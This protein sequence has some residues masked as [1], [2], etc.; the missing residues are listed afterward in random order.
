MNE[1]DGR[2][3]ALIQMEDYCEARKRS[4]ILGKVKGIKN[5]SSIK[6]AK[7]R[8]LIP[9]VRNKDGEAEKTRQ[10]IENVFAIFYEDLYQGED[11]HNDEDMSSC[12]D[13][14]NADSSQIETFPEFTTE[15]IQAAVD[16]LKKGKAR[17]SNGI[18]AE[19]LQICS[20]DTKE[21][22]RTIFNEFV[23][24]EDFTPKIWRRIRIQVIHK[25]GDRE[26]PGNYRPICG[27]PILYK[28]IATVLYARLAPLFTNYILLTRLV[29]GQTID[30][31][32]T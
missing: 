9:K 15:E 18:R 23:Q 12:I 11:D 24:Q 3:R 25:K 2:I 4:K 10:G 1:E 16:R 5:I 21:K 29:S 7:K 31:R 6:S 26:D 14:E 19:Q 20:E 17:D 8:I 27:L 22:I 32:I 28:L 30:V 13:H